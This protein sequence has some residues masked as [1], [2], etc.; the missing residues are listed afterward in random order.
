MKLDKYYNN[1][2]FDGGEV[3]CIYIN[4]TYDNFKVRQ[5]GDVRVDIILLIENDYFM[6]RFDQD[7]IG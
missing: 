3:V 4:G 5:N 2:Q 6:V 1:K 7:D